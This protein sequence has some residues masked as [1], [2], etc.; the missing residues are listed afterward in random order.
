MASKCST[1]AAPLRPK[2]YCYGV[3]EGGDAAFKKVKELYMA[4]NVA[5][6]KDIL[7]RALGCHKDVVALKELLFLTIDRNAAF[8][9]LQDVRDLFNSIS[10]NPA[11]QE[12]ILNFLLERWDDIYNGYTELSTII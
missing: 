7:R 12:L 6:E 10:E 8:V 1:V 9:R 11:G 2:T 5:L 4:E 3:R